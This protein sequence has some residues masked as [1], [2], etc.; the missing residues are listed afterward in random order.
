MGDAA[1][2]SLNVKS[3]GGSSRSV[4][5]ETEAG[6]EAEAE[7]EAEAG[8]EAGA[9]A[10]AGAEAEAGAGAEAEAGADD[11]RAAALDTAAKTSAARRAPS[12]DVRDGGWEARGRLIIRKSLV[13]LP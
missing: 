5:L 9:G 13:F 4:G 2:S 6:P 1:S 3:L 10:G 11:R 7:A 8:A 12:D